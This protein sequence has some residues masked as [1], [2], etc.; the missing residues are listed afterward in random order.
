M[1]QTEVLTRVTHVNGWKPTDYISYT[2]QSLHL[3]QLSYLSVQK[4]PYFLLPCSRVSVSPRLPRHPPG[5]HGRATKTGAGSPP[6]GA[7]QRRRRQGGE[8]NCPGSPTVQ[9][10]RRC[11]FVPAPT[12]FRCAITAQRRRPGK[13]PSKQ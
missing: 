12:P 7:E 3:F 1:K 10:R 9:P 11:L 2:S 6:A 8:R 4:L 13:W 5:A